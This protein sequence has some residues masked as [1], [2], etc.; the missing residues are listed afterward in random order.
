MF[1]NDYKLIKKSGLF[2]EHYYLKNNQDARKADID[3]IRHYLRDGWKEGKNPS[4]RFDTNFYLTTYPDVAAVGLNPLVHYLKY[5][6][7]EGR[8]C[9]PSDQTGPQTAE[10]SKMKKLFLISKYAQNNPYL[11]KNF[12][13][14]AR[15]NGITYA[16]NRARSKL[17]SSNSPIAPK[18]YCYTAPILSKDI[19]NEMKNFTRKPLISIIMPV[20][21]VDPKWLE[22]AIKSVEAQWYNNWELCIA[23]DKST[24]EDTI[25]YLKDIKNSKIKIKFLEKNVN[26]STASNEASKLA[27]GEYIVLLDNDDELTPDAL[28]EIVKVINQHNPDFIYSDEDKLELDG[29]HTFPFFKPDFSYDLLLSLNYITHLAT[30]KKE[31]FDKISGF[32]VGVE[33]AQDHD[34]FLRIV[35]QTDKIVHI[36]KVLYHWRMLETST[37]KTSDAKPYAHNAAKKAIQ[38]HLNRIGTKATVIDSEYTFVFD[39]NYNLPE[40][41]PLVSI[42]IP[43]KDGINFLDVCI[44]SILELSTYTNYEI[45]ILNNNST[46]NETFEW[47]NKIQQLHSNIKVIEA[48]YKFNWSKLN[49]HGIQE[50]KGDV[51]IFLNNDIKIITNDWI[52]RLVSRALQPSVGTVGA[53]LL[54][55]DNTIQHAGVV[56]GMNGWADHVYRETRQVHMHSPYVSPMVT[57]NVLAS[58]GACLAISKNTIDTIGKFDEDFLICGSDVEISLRAYQRGYRN[59]FDA[60]TKLYHYESKTRDSFVPECDFDMSRKAYQFYWKNGDPFY[61]HNLKLDSVIPTYKGQS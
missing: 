2:D 11:I 17:H 41:Q 45:I 29:S 60:N 56:V 9:N 26:I 28:Y 55:D 3:P 43:T 50:S 27:K 25:K 35:E 57:R 18:P 58:T 52:E 7:K 5:G 32:H 48:N 44:K 54:F 59:I 33:G 47:F 14:E 24:N 20:Y 36:P 16:M 21:N 13:F 39:I 15:R 31:I 46:E 53:L 4:E 1:K 30:I 49:N 40:P 10:V 42:I 37:A 6:K 12:I 22:L 8:K 34:L 23:D 51:Y 38:D 19:R 61:N